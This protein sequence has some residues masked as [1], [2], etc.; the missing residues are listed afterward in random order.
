VQEIKI[1]FLDAFTNLITAVT[2]PLGHIGETW[3]LRTVTNTAP[4]D[5]A[6]VRGVVAV[7]E[8]G[9]Y[10]ALQFDVLEMKQW[11]DSS[12][13]ANLLKN[14]SFEQD[15]AVLTI[16]P[17]YWHMGRPDGNGDSWGN[18]SVRDWRAHSGSHE[19][20]IA[21]SW[22][23]GYDYG[24]VWQQ[25]PADAGKTYQFS[26]W[27]WADA[28]TYGTWFAS[29]QHM[30]LEFLDADLNFLD[31]ELLYLQGIGETWE[32]KT[33]SALAPPD[34]AWARVAII[35]E[36][37]DVEGALQFDDLELVEDPPVPE[38]VSVTI[39]DWIAVGDWAEVEVEVR[40]VGGSGYG[41]ISVSM[42]D[43]ASSLDGVRVVDNGTM[44]SYSNYPQGNT[45]LHKD[46]YTLPAD[47]MLVE[48]YVYS[49]NADETSILKFRVQP[50]VVGDFTLQ[51]RSTMR[52]SDTLNNTPIASDV[53]DQQGWRVDVHTISVEPPPSPEILSISVP[54]SITV[55]ESAD[56]E[57]RAR[58]NGGV[59]FGGISASC[60][61]LNS[62]G[63]EQYVTD[64]GSTAPYFEYEYGDMIQDKD[65]Q[66]MS[67]SHVLVECRPGVWDEDETYVLKFRVQPQSVGN[68]TLRIRSTL[69]QVDEKY[70][71]PT[72]GAVDQQGWW[73]TEQAINVQPDSNPPGPDPMTWAQ[74]PHPVDTSS[75]SMSATTA[76]DPEGNG[77]EYLFDETSGNA[78]ANDSGWQDSPSYTDDGL[79][80]GVTYSY[81]VKARDKSANQNETA[82][83]EVESSGV[84]D[85][86]EVDDDMVNQ[87]R[88][89][90]AGVAQNH[91]FHNQ[92]DIDNVKFDGVANHT[93][94]IETYNV[95]SGW[96][97]NVSLRQ[98]DPSVILASELNL[99]GGVSFTYEVNESR[100][101]YVRLTQRSGTGSG[102]YTLKIS[103][104]GVQSP[105][106]LS[107][108]S[109]SQAADSGFVEVFYDLSSTSSEVDIRLLV[110]D[111][112]GATF[113][114]PVTS[115]TGDGLVAPGQ[116]LNIVWDAS[117]D[118]PDSFST[119]MQVRL[120]ADDTV[121]R[122]SDRFSL[123][124]RNLA[125]GTISGRIVCEGHAVA[126]AL[127][128]VD[129]TLKRSYSDAE[130]Y[131]HISDVSVGR[132]YLLKI[133]ANGYVTR[134]LDGVNVLEDTVNL[135]EVELS[136]LGNQFR[137]IR[138]VPDVNPEISVIEE[139]GT[140]YRYYRVVTPA[141]G[142]PAGGVTVSARLQG[143]EQILQD[144]ESDVWAGRL[145][146]ISDD[147]GIVRIE[148]PSSYFDMAGTEYVE[149]LHSG[150]IQQ[151]F[152]VKMVGR[153]Y[154]KVW[155]HEVGGGVSGKAFVF[156]R[157]S[158]SGS[159][160]SEVRHTMRNET[161]FEEKITRRRAGEL[162]GGFE[163][164]SG[165]RLGA[166][167]SAKVGVGGYFGADL[168]S[169]YVFDP[170][171]VNPVENAMKLYVA[172][173]DPLQRA[174]GPF[175]GF[176]NYVRHHYEPMFLESR[177]KSVE[178]NIRFGGYGELEAGIGVKGG[179]L[180][181]LGVHAELSSELGLVYGQVYDFTPIERE[182]S[183]LGIS[184]SARGS[185]G[186]GLL[187]PALAGE[188][189][190][191]PLPFCGFLASG[192]Y[193][194]ELLG[195]SS[196][197]YGR[198]EELGLK[199][200]VAFEGSVG[201]AMRNMGY[202]I[203]DADLS[204][205][206]VTEAKE[207]Y[208]FSIP[209]EGVEQLN[210]LA[211][212][213]YGLTS[214]GDPGST[215]RAD[216]PPEM[217]LSMFQLAI[218]SSSWVDYEKSLY[219]ARKVDIG[220]DID[221]DPFVAGIGLSIHGRL[222]RGVDSVCERGRILRYKRMALEAYDPTALDLIPVDEIFDLEGLWA[223]RAVGPISDAFDAFS[224][225][226]NE[227]AETI[228]ETAG[229]V[230]NGVNATLEIGAGSVAGAGEILCESIAGITGSAQPDEML[231][232]IA[233]SGSIATKSDVETEW[234]PPNQSNWVY[235]IGGV[236]RFSSTNDFVGTGT[237]SIAYTDAEIIGLNENL[238]KIYRASEDASRWDLV[239]GTVQP[240]SNRVSCVVTQWG[241]YAV[242]PPLPT[243]EFQIE[244]TPETL[245]AGSGSV[246]TALVF[247]IFLNNG[248]VATNPWLFTV[249]GSG[250]NVL[251]ED[252][253]TNFPGLQIAMADG[254][255][256]ASAVA[257]PGGRDVSLHLWSLCGDAMGSIS[258]P[259]ID[260][261]SP[262][263]PSNVLTS[264]GQSRIEVRWSA[265]SS[266]D[267]E[268]YRVYYRGGS[269]GPPYDGTATVEGVSSPVEV[270]AEEVTL[271]GLDNN[272]AYYIA[273]AAVDA[274]GNESELAHGAS[275]TTAAAAPSSPK[276]VASRFYDAGTNVLMWSLS[277]DDGYNDRDVIRYDIYRVVKPG[278]NYVKCGEVESGIE[279]Y[280]ESAFSV[281]PT[282]YIRYAVSAVDVQGRTSSMIRANHV[283]VPSGV[284]DNDWDLVDDQWEEEHGLNP[285]DRTDG[286]SD[287][288]SDGMVN[289][290]EYWAGT[291][292]QDRF[293]LLRVFFASAPSGGH[294]PIQF[295]SVAGK[296]YGVL[297]CSNLVEGIWMPALYALTPTGTVT[298]R[299]V[300]ATTSEVT[301]YVEPPPEGCF[302]RVDL[303]HE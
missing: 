140:A 263:A 224:Q 62:G 155:K 188:S 265:S 5:T 230:A 110:S 203:S 236:V 118:W 84:Y 23:L 106:I 259:L 243:G 258:I 133:S 191:S 83:S 253:S 117:V 17:Y 251:N 143:G 245:V 176:Y 193:A 73:V 112:G 46:G 284:V 192:G 93:Y 220:V 201:F 227:G 18:A 3:V 175:V 136:E 164:G 146:G 127:I 60:P 88:V 200:N 77:V 194:F 80:G 107:N 2:N 261:Q 15:G 97:M 104:L 95:S 187:F 177:L 86:Y 267:V 255:L 217:L 37:A 280:T 207:A 268:K 160:E 109:A 24:G 215:I 9:E 149:I 26:S 254:Q 294:V 53:E 63:D 34:T 196:Y 225:A 119:D 114:V 202:P 71:T 69:Q 303:N 42:P 275:V 183:V 218:H 14:S 102:S 182:T 286:L 274:M 163:V 115:V 246:L 210:L 147:D 222:E 129:T 40:N 39:P 186:V 226:L 231:V 22:S 271:R 180:V 91:I 276:A 66:D 121:S 167:G 78:G 159:Y 283:L 139:G 244:V 297:A 100:T 54:S 172:L 125:F 289:L 61:Q 138:L 50:K 152:P 85:A 184:G 25:A 240:L 170:D 277:E 10:G 242:A 130:G 30:K 16:E 232:K 229:Q 27:F 235:G 6:W 270:S 45:I 7:E 199:Y 32:Q 92:D 90:V 250:I 33:I 79:S 266:P 285:E 272:S 162:R 52:I 151:V 82:Y 264:A 8:A 260:D 223:C 262:I 248:S 11:T 81:R 12:W 195:S 197:T 219:R 68:F 204:F 128:E 233:E 64:I 150:S 13:G 252:A 278:G 298:S 124:T 295:S 165:I 234:P 154:D 35:A 74:A 241:T 101:Y 287:F 142:T 103:D 290:H 65:S 89:I 296:E 153:E 148:L 168:A 212:I 238:L 1:E 36:G 48:G 51:I 105:P 43:L 29:T 21:G 87:A 137:V 67:A 189:D 178:G 123:D 181:Q 301:I 247:N 120:I 99:D 209:D 157:A 31:T 113:N 257:P 161:V 108:V 256:A 19:M 216:L 171:S 174:A 41:G 98:V 47:Y 228:V 122:D 55:G 190:D 70:T 213:W 145:A 211:P 214:A 282:E 198:L 94:K 292:P 279:T 38:I 156:S 269:D 288:D 44:G 144:H 59:C 206:G 249:E 237:L 291:D 134:R 221:I 158:M 273:V 299:T 300:R 205:E 131:F 173:G 293:S 49:W 116:N 72:S 281:S 179:D 239:G 4:E 75:I 58:N 126:D 28:G 96:G 20:T 111:D 57:V 208:S 302:Y 166:G 132:K 76:I 135:G 169:T 185:L 56:I 141:D